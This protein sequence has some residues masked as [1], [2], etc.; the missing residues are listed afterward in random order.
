VAQSEV[1]PYYKAPL[2]KLERLLGLRRP[3]V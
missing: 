1:S 3:P 2:F